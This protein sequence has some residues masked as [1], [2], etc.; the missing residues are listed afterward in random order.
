M[1]NTKQIITKLKQV[2]DEKGL[3][4]NEIVL[5]VE[6]N[7]DYVS[8][9]TVQRV[10][11][12]GSEDISFR[13]EDSIRPIANALLDIET[14]EDTD[15][16]DIQAMK[17]LLKYKI[18]RIK[19]LEQQLDKE[20][21]KYHEKLDKEREQSRK[22]IEFL[23]EQIAYKDKRMDLLLESIKEKDAH[24]DTLLKHILECPYRK[25]EDKK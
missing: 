19:E 13:Y 4:L 3:S 15:S 12:D 2:R 18:D 8:R 10:F 9:S 22:S 14:I 25:C 23:K 7:G 1:E 21:I 24:Y 5:L 16:M 11:S 20:K 6:K 17:V